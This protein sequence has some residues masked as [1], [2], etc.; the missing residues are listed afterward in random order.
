MNWFLGG[1]AV[2][3]AAAIPL[4]YYCRGLARRS[5]ARRRAADIEAEAAELRREA[6]NWELIIEQLD[7]LHRTTGFN[8]SARRKEAQK[9]LEQLRRGERCDS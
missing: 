9:A 1:I 5:R 7:T 4:Y 3:V 2:T 6:E 8:V